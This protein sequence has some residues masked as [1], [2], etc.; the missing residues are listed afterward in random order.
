[1]PVFQAFKETRVLIFI[2]LIYINFFV[3]KFLVT[4]FSNYSVLKTYTYIC[5]VTYPDGL[6]EVINKHISEANNGGMF[7]KGYHFLKAWQRN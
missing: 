5:G 4:L 7:P 2:Y 1:M 3:C 6:Y